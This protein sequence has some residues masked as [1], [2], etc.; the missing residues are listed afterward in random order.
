[1]TK[2]VIISI[3]NDFMEFNIDIENNKNEDEIYAYIVNYVLC[4]I[5]IEVI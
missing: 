4:N 2:T 5:N 1:M 3:D